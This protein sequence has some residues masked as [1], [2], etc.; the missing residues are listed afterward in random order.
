MLQWLRLRLGI[1]IVDFSLSIWIVTHRLG[2]ETKTVGFTIGFWF[3]SFDRDY[4]AVKM[5]YLKEMGWESTFMWYFGDANRWYL[6]I[7]EP[8]VTKFDKYATILPP[9]LDPHQ[10]VER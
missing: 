8:E 6:P 5:W 4:D 7:P 10:Q 1:Q 2:D 3:L 9:V